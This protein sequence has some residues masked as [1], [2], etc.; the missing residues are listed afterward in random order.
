MERLPKYVLIIVD[1]TVLLIMLFIAFVI[2]LN[3]GGEIGLR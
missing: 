1:I 3:V 2:V